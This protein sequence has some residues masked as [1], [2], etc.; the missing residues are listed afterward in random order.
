MPLRVTKPHP[1]LLDVKRIMAI[2]DSL[3]TSNRAG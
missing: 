2:T 1:S 3:S